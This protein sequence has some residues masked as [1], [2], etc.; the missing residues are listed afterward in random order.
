VS[1]PKEGQKPLP[2]EGARILYHKKRRISIEYEK[3]LVYYFMRSFDHRV[4]LWIEL[5][6]SHRTRDKCYVNFV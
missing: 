3:F 4:M 6:R 2:F 5:A 1:T